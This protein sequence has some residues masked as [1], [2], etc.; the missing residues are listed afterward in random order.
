MS[1]PVRRIGVLI[2]FSGLLK[3][4]R[5]SMKVETLPNEQLRQIEQRMAVIESDFRQLRYVELQTQE[6]HFIIMII[7]IMMMMMIVIIIMIIIMM[8]III[9]IIIIMMIVITIMMIVII[10]I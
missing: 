6:R 7:I 8:I 9:M 10:I 1:G 4:Q 5:E 2:P 3:H